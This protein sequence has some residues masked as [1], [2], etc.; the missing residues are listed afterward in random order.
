MEKN[1][2]SGI[3]RRKFFKVFGTG[4]VVS[5][6][7]FYGCKDNTKS[8]VVSGKGEIP[9]DKMTYRTS[10]TTGDQGFAFRLWLHAIT[11]NIPKQ[12]KG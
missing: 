2:K 12:C 10:P 9:T 8:S 1:N 3:D 11:D 7:A 4:A 6:A 5:A